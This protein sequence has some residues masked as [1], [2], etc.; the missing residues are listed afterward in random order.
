MKQIQQRFLPQEDYL[1]LAVVGHTNTGKTSLLRTLL[2]DAD[3]GE[4]ANGARFVQASQLSLNGTGIGT[5]NDRLRDAIR[6][7]GASDRCSRSAG[8]GGCRPA[9]R[10]RRCGPWP[11]AS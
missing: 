11:A 1:K 7:G 9:R 3:F 10:P 6:G 4:V 2:H 8:R 5:F